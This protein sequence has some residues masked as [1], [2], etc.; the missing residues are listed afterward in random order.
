[1]AILELSVSS[2][3]ASDVR[4][5]VLVLGAQANGGVAELLAPAGFESLAGSLAAIGATGA[6]D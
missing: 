5:D 3:R 6:A 2:A 4:A 1:M